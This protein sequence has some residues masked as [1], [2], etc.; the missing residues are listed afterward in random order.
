MPIFFFLVMLP[1]IPILALIEKWPALNR[2]L[3]LNESPSVT[4]IGPLISLI[5]WV[6]VLSLSAIYSWWILPAFIAILFAIAAY[7]EVL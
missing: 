2:K 4:V 1:A 3:G 5:E 6:V 7:Y